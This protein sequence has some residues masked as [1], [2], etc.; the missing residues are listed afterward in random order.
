MAQQLSDSRRALAIKR[1]DEKRGLRT[2]LF[3]YVVVNAMLL[4]IW[5]FMGAGFLW[6]IF[7]IAIWGMGLV[8]HAYTVYGGNVYTESEVQNEMAKLP[9]DAAELPTR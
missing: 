4:V 5:Y 9:K 8:I 2:H 3:T 7:P 6:P 1:I